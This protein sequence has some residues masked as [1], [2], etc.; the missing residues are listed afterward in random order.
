M[1]LYFLRLLGWSLGGG[2]CYGYFGANCTGSYNGGTNGG[3]GEGPSTPIDDE[4]E[5]SGAAG[6]GTGKLL[7][8]YYLEHFSLAPGRGGDEFQFLQND[9]YGGG[10]GGVL[11]NGEGP[12]RRCA[13]LYN[14]E[15]YG[16]GGS[17][18]QRF[19][20]EGYCAEGLTGV[21]LVEVGP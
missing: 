5:E 11:V 6:H 17:G 9:I 1:S 3:N 8:D 14:G 13:T 4:D 10:G 18:Y 12:K 15:G 21:V 16:A 7:S 19:G 20:V 2:S